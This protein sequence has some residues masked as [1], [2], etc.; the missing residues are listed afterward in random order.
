L[1]VSTPFPYTTLFRSDTRVAQPA[2]GLADLAAATVLDRFRVRADMVAG[3][4][5]GE[6]V[7][8][9]AAGALDTPALL[10]LSEARGRAMVDA[11]PRSEEHTSELQSRENL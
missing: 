1:P 4:S 5:Y 8:L 9:C 11:V 10:A 6:L 7:A 3:H 2:L